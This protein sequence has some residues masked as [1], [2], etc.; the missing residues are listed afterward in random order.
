MTEDPLFGPLI[1]FGM[2]GVLVELVGD[3]SFRITP[4]T[5]LEA[6]DMVREIKSAKLLDGY[7][8]YP[9][10]DISAVEEVILRVSTLADSIPEVQEM[11]LNPVMVL[12][13]G[14]GAKAVDARIRIA[15]TAEGWSPE[16]VDV[17]G[18]VD[19]PKVTAGG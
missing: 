16:L 8:S 4:V 10:G 3:V 5:N 1:V 12:A 18:R 19:R 17:P 14:E 6:A 13:P 7:R 15:P 11:D 2:G 9:A